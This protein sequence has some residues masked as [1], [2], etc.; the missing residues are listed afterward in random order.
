MN[1][2]LKKFFHGYISHLFLPS[3]SVFPPPLSYCLQLSMKAPGKQDPR[4]V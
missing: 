3:C 4:R 1:S 2:G